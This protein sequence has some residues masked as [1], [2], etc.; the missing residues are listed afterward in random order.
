MAFI[1]GKQLADSTV[2]SAKLKLD[3]GTYD[4][5]QGAVLQ[6]SS[7]SN[8]SDVATKTYVDSLSTSSAAG[9]DFKES[10]FVAT[11]G[12]LSATYSGGVLTGAA[13]G[14]ISV[15]GESPIAGQRILV[16]DQTTASHNGIYTVTL[17]GDGSNAFTLT[18][19]ADADSSSDLTTGAFIFVE[20]GSDNQNKSFVLQANGDGSSP[21]LD[22][23]DL[24]F[25]QFSGAGQITVG[26]GLSKDVDQ[27]NLN[28]IGLSTKMN[29]SVAYLQD[30]LVMI[31]AGTGTAEKL[32]IGNF[33][34]NALNTNSGLETLSGSTGKLTVKAGAGI[35]LDSNGVNAALPQVDSGSP[36]ATAASDGD[37]TGITISATPAGDS[38]VRVTV[39][40]VGIKLGD[41]ATTGCDAYFDDGASGARSIADI[42]SGDELLWNG[43]INGEGSYELE[44][45]DIVEIFYNA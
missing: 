5:S 18:R 10:V 14:A 11:T 15:D 29:G 9:L 20:A 8:G 22:T 17:V 38:H 26:Q 35:S 6:A 23:D 32:T 40:G 24:T 21:T 36:L 3:S 34:S 45:S 28:F 12:N 41:G 39:N 13:A 37:S 31:D 1:K 43:D 7:P 2:T 4:F 27:I 44:T 16:K 25:I 33:L 30:Y 19:A 42:A